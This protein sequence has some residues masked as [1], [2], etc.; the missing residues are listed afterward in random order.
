VQIEADSAD[1]ARQRLAF[2]QDRL[3]AGL[4][5]QIQFDQ[6]QLAYSQAELALLQAQHEYLNSL[7]RLAAGTLV[8][9]DGPAVLTPE[10]PRFDSALNSAFD[11]ATGPGDDD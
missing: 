11:S 7:L 8:P 1:N 10:L 2:Q 5:A 9:L 3:A 4:I 6:E